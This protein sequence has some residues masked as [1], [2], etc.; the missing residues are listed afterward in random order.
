MIPKQIETE[1]LIRCKR[2]CAVCYGL[3]LDTSIQKGQIAHLDKDS[4]NSELDNLV[5]LCFNHHDEYDSRTSQSKGLTEGEIRHFRDDL[6]T[7]IAKT[8]K[9]SN[10]FNIT[11]L[12]DINNF[13]G[14]YVWEN[15]NATAELDIRAVG[16]NEIE[17]S[18]LAFWGTTSPQGPNIG[19]VDFKEILCNNE[20]LHVDP[21]SGYEMHITFTQ[22]GLLLDEKN[23]EGQF[24][25][26]VR[27]AGEFKRSEKVN[28]TDIAIN[29]N[30]EVHVHDGNIFL[31]EEGIERQLTF[32]GLDRNPLLMKNGAILF[33]RQEEALAYSDDRPSS[34][35]KYYTHQILTV[36]IKTSFEK[37]VTDE[38]PYEDGLNGTKKILQIRTPTL[39]LDQNF[40]YF[41]AEKYATGSQFVK[42]NIGSGKW[43]E[44]FSAESFEVVQKDDGT[45]LFL[46]AISEIRNRGRDIYY[47]LCDEAG[48]VLKEFDTQDSMLKFKK[49]VNG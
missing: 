25:M 24:G 18:G 20:I 49:S 29:S 30:I 12:I 34:S 15:Q 4:A 13:S 43:I 32:W 37:L 36:D 48:T 44:L 16:N 14:H 47:K 8:W 22:Q 46:V 19:Q 28:Q 31:A 35:W 11:P 33:V 6:I 2:R 17:V 1:V 23:I 26:N 3:N 39:S 5:F 9:E 10:P 21:A 41:V 27:F 7:R 45:W 42:V 38:K 40:V